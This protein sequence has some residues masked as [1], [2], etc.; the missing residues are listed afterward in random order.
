MDKSEVESILKD[1]LWYL[2]QEIDELKNNISDLN[3]RFKSH[4]NNVDEAHKI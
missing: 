1:K 3:K 4:I 2:N